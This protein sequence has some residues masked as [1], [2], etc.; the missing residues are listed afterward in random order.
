MLPMR[1]D[2]RERID[3]EVCRPRAIDEPADQPWADKPSEIADRVDEGNS[4]RSGRAGENGS[5]QAPEQ[6]ERGRDAGH[7]ERHP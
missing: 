4:S 7:R 3:A 1:H 2:A 6:R 5:G